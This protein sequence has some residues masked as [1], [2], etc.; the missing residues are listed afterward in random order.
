MRLGGLAGRKGGVDLQGFD[1][2][3]ICLGHGLL[4]AWTWLRLW[5]HLIIGDLI[6]NSFALRPRHLEGVLGDEDREVRKDCKRI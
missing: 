3:T 6:S 2:G 5:R 4:L 1:C